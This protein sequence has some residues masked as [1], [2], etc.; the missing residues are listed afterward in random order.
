[1]FS[2]AWTN[3]LGGR[4]ISSFDS[5]QKKA[6]EKP[7]TESSEMMN[8]QNNKKKVEKKMFSRW[9][10]YVFHLKLYRLLRWCFKEHT[11]PF[12]S[13][14]KSICLKKM[15]SNG[16]V[17]KRMCDVI[18]DLRSGKIF[19]RFSFAICQLFFSSLTHTHSTT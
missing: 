2:D 17:E 10:K 11:Y 19:F 14:K 13:H 6:L 7:S 5:K 1:M 18:R 16:R 15:S 4:I 8:E 12:H 3:S 9:E